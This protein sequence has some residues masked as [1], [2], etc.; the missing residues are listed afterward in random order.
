[1]FV[2]KHLKVNHVWSWWLG[3]VCSLFVHHI[4]RGSG[5][6]LVPYGKLNA[7]HLLEMLV[8]VKIALLFAGTKHVGHARKC[9]PGRPEL[10]LFYCEDQ[11]TCS[12]T[13]RLFGEQKLWEHEEFGL[14][15]NDSSVQALSS[16]DSGVTGVFARRQSCNE[17]F[18]FHCLVKE[19]RRGFDLRLVIRSCWP[20]TF[21]NFWSAGSRKK[22]FTAG[23]KRGKEKWFA[24]SK[25]LTSEIAHLRHNNN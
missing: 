7:V 19:M 3:L 1:M 9:E 10:P 8:K 12:C 22:G 13:G 23:W 18:Y 2:D 21:L 14:L 15:M 16:S 4:M 20:F 17:V 24:Q 25:S 6:T 11:R 5:T